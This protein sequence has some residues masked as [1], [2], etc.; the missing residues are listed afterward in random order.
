ML[1]GWPALH[2]R[3]PDL[4]RIAKAL[5]ISAERL[6]QAMESLCPDRDT[7]EADDDLAGTAD[8]AEGQE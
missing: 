8:T 7:T 5:G 3:V 1:D 2:L 6:T 4:T